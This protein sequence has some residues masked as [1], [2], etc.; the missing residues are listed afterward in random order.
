MPSV[1]GS[2][3]RMA[4][5]TAAAPAA[6]PASNLTESTLRMGCSRQGRYS[7]GFSEP[8]NR[9]GSTSLATPTTVARPPASGSVLPMG[10]CR[11]QKARA[12]R[13][14]TITDAGSQRLNS[15][16]WSRGMP[17]VSKNAGEAE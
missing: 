16:P 15:R 14:E 17:S 5:R 3:S 9:S 8:P 13:F 1:L 12:S 6:S 10:S 2:T 11:G 4:A 7:A